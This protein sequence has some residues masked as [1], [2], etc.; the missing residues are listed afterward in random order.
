M[1][2]RQI[3]DLKEIQKLQTNVLVYFDKICKE[4][5]LKYFLVGGTLL[6]AIRHKG[7][8]PWDDDI[9]VC[10]PRSDYE[11][12][13]SISD[14]LEKDYIVL[15]PES[16]NNYMLV[17]SKLANKNYYNYRK[18]LNGKY[19]VRMDIFPVDGLGNDYGTAVKQMKR[20]TVARKIFSVCFKNNIFSK[21]LHKL[22]VHRLG[23]KLMIKQ[24]KKY[25][26]QES[27]YVGCIAGGMKGEKD[28]FKKEIYNK[29]EN[30]TF[31]GHK[32]PGLIYYDKY[33]KQMYGDYMKLPPKSEQINHGVEVFD[34][35]G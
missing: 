25:K 34:M 9:D 8:I 21:L 26:Y 32:L 29:L 12:F 17:F 22:N 1:K 6:G 30:V 5:N 23:Y 18:G 11:Q 28:I 3:T 14:K 27:E 10:M 4:N 20:I 31:E 24:C 16:N 33:L 19:G 7:F 13:L 15:S 35:R 2:N